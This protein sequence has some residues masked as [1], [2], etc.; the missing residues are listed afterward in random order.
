[1]KKKSLL[2]IYLNCLI[3]II[4][5]SCFLGGQSKEDTTISDTK[6]A[7][8][9]FSSELFTNVNV[10]DAVAVTEVYI[11]LIAKNITDYKVKTKIIDSLSL[12]IKTIN[13]NEVDVIYLTA[14]EYLNIKEKTKI[15]PVLN[16]ASQGEIV[17]S[18]VL[19]IRKDSGINNLE[20]LRNKNIIIRKGGRGKIGLIW[21][22]T[23]LLKNGLSESN[24][25]FKN[26]KEVN[27]A[28]QSVLP[29]FFK[30]TDVCLVTK[31][32]F[33]T[34]NE[35]NPQIGNE[36]KILKTSP[37]F[38]YGITCC[39]DGI[40]MS[41]REDVI[42]EALNLHKDVIGKQLLT[43]HRLDKVVLFKK[44]N[45]KSLKELIKEYNSLKELTEVKIK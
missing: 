6:Y 29:V 32:S 19:L 13:N 44:S 43:I 8:F 33:N 3:L 10:K 2:R 27:K 34:M 45:L 5:S 39:R 40:N 16:A 38:I 7:R 17:E 26:I 15:E 23:I 21:L 36:I 25:F 41:M 22:D 20:K 28:S 37:G 14:L 18:Y 35:L 11:Q 9:G 4:L 24:D 12:L 1:M 30:Q 42:R 31:R